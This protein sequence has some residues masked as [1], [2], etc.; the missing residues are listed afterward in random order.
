V[1]ASHYNHFIELKDGRTILAYNSYSGALAEIEQENFVRVKQLLTNPN[2]CESTSDREF[3]QCLQ[4]GGFLI[5]DMVDQAAAVMTKSRSVRLEG[6]LLALTI[7]PTLACNFACDYCFESRSSLVMSEET[8]EAL[9]RFADRHLVRAEALRISWFGGEPTLCFHLIEKLQYRFLE[10]AEKHHTELVPGQIITN[11][12]LL[13]ETKAQR[14]KDL[15]VTHA[16]VTIDGPKEV[17]DARRKLRNGKGTFDR[18]LENLSVVAGILSINVRI[19][20]DK[21]NV[22]SACEVAEILQQKG[23]LDKVRVTFAQ[24]QSSGHTCSDI[25][26]R[27]Y[28]NAGFARTLVQIQNR[29]ISKGICRVNSPRIGSGATCGAVADGNFVVS[30]NGFLFRCWEDLSI[31]GEMSIGNLFSPV[32][33]DRQKQNLHAYRSW[34]PFKLSECKSCKILPICLGGC[35]LST[36]RATEATHGDCAPWKYNL[37]DVI[38]LAYLCQAKPTSEIPLSTETIQERD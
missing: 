31:D 4:D 38:E 22:D 24:V 32:L 21:E 3:L 1:K 28:D 9:I 7:A 13:D 20:V 19:N 33:E 27:C 2:L 17:H 29:L 16:Q 11:A 34:D 26:D 14:L 35:P 36:L 37:K 6:M 15:Q 10:L 5:P 8:Q 18:I 23:I 25:R 30:P 12:Y